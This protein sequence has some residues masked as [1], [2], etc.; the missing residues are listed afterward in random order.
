MTRF[1][2]LCTVLSLLVIGGLG[3]ALTAR[4]DTVYFPG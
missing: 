3:P 1:A 2:L 4:A